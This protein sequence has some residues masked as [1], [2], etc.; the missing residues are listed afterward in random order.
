MRLHKK[1]EETKSVEDL[2]RSGRPCKLSEDEE[3][4]AISQLKKPFM[5]TRTVS[6]EFNV[7]HTLISDLASEYDIEYKHYIEVPKLTEQHKI[8]RFNFCEFFLND[9]YEYWIFTDECSF[10]LFRNTQGIWTRD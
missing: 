10:Q 7:S 5:S 1:Y 8:N 3:I 9:D 4:K 6:A 2:P